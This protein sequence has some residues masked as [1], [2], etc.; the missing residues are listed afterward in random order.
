MARDEQTQGPH[1]WSREAHILFLVLYKVLGWGS[2]KSI[3]SSTTSVV[4]A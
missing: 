2:K 3:I 1:A 4:C